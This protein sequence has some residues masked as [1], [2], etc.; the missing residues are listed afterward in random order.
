MLKTTHANDYTITTDDYN[1][2]SSYVN[3]VAAIC[4]GSANAAGWWNNPVENGTKFM[5]MVSEIAEAMEGDRK[6]SM[7]DHLPHRTAVEVELA[8]AV[9]RIMDFAGG[10]NLDLGGALA[11]KLHYNQT[12][13][14]HKLENRAK[15]G[16]KK[17]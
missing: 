9:I 17:Y 5:L 12:R 15:I 16:G 2:L 14:D 1:A 3:N 7:D 8:D 4:Y 11:E 13:A 10:K 6:Q